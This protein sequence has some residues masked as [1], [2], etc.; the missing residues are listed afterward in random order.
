[1]S[2]AVSLRDW[3]E[4]HITN[5]D[6]SITVIIEDIC[7][8][9]KGIRNRRLIQLKLR[10]LEFS[11]GISIHHSTEKCFIESNFYNVPLK[12]TNEVS[13][14]LF[15]FSGCTIFQTRTPHVW[16]GI[17]IQ[18][19]KGR[20]GSI[21]AEINKR[22][23]HRVRTQDASDLIFGG[24]QKHNVYKKCKVT[25]FA[26]IRY[27]KQRSLREQRPFC[28]RRTRGLPPVCQRGDGCRSFQ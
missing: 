1:M 18:A 26:S 20:A 5:E 19:A 13:I 15:L 7:I 14:N 6:Y 25:S 17:C 21:A 16:N 2:I 12:M 11:I 27:K 9:R 28:S 22:I 23:V 10:I 4:I 3:D 8:D 24:E